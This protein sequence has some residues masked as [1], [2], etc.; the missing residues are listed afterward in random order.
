MT[1]FRV[2]T[3]DKRRPQ[4]DHVYQRFATFWAQLRVIEDGKEDRNVLKEGEAMNDLAF[5]DWMCMKGPDSLEAVLEEFL[6]Y[7]MQR[8]TQ[9]LTTEHVTNEVV[10]YM[11]LASTQLKG[12]D[13]RTYLQAAQGEVA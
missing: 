10:K 12:P 5:M 9:P 8:E 11:D 7:R 4:I 6:T 1:W 2:R 3:G 13:G